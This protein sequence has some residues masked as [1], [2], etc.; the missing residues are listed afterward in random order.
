MAASPTNV[1]L[2]PLQR[3]AGGRSYMSLRKIEASSVAAISAGT[4]CAQSPKR[5]SK[6]FLWPSGPAFSPRGSLVTPA[7]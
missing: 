5:S 2:P 4:G 7:Q 1:T 6:S 3:C